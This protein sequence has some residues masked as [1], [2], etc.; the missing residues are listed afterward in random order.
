[1]PNQYFNLKNTT[2]F[3]IEKFLIDKNSDRRL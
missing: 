1:M 2:K 3:K